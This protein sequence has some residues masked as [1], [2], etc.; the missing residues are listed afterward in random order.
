MEAQHVSFVDRFSATLDEVVGDC[1][2][3]MQTSGFTSSAWCPEAKALEMA[4]AP[5]IVCFVLKSPSYADLGEQV[6]LLA[7]KVLPSALIHYASTELIR[8]SGD[9]EDA[10]DFPA[11]VASVVQR[12]LLENPLSD[13]A[14]YRVTTPYPSESPSVLRA[15]A[16]DASSSTGALAKVDEFT[17]TLCE[18]ANATFVVY[19]SSNN[20]APTRTAAPRAEVLDVRTS[21]CP[22]FFAVYVLGRELSSNFFPKDVYV[23]DQPHTARPRKVNGAAATRAKRGEGGSEEGI[24]LPGGITDA[25]LCALRACTVASMVGGTTV[26]KWG[27]RA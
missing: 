27:E 23:D 15:G 17:E 12:L 4:G 5:R 25:V 10:D 3:D 9:E 26:L 24:E 19:A 21:D 13:M 8:R 7:T 16:R 6:E 22:V 14:F 20:A 2:A 11:G 1:F 18:T